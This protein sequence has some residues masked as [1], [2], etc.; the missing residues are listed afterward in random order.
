M[1]FTANDQPDRDPA[2]E[3]S[4][5]FCPYCATALEV[6]HAEE[7]PRM[8]CP[9]GHFVHYRNPVPAAGVIITKANRILLVRRRFE[10]KAGLWSLP[11][12]FLEYGESPERCAVRELAEETGLSGEIQGLHGVYAAGD[13]P[14]TKVV[15]I[16]YLAR[17]TGGDLQP[18][19]DADR[20]DYF[21]MDDL[22][23]L[24]WSSHRRAF[25]D[26]QR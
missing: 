12:G 1:N 18:G 24:A 22:P 26:F 7:V 5:R 25:A 15:L 9:K 16:I 19:D 14:R 13:D 8:A 23:E 11:A 20:V 10:P 21:P 3:G 6:S 17:I 4:F 2:L